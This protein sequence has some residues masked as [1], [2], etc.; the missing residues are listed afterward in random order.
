MGKVNVE[1]NARKFIKQDDIHEAQHDKNLYNT[2]N[3]VL[4]KKIRRN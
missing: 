4:N 2:I 1:D 3:S